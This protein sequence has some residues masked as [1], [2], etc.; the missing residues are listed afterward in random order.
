MN[1]FHFYP[2]FANDRRIAREASAER[3]RL[4]RGARAAAARHFSPGLTLARSAVRT[5]AAV[6]TTRA[7]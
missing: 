2:T 5:T 7:A 4:L 1:D 3:H 6:A